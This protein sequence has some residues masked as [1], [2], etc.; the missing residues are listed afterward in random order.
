MDVSKPLDKTSVIPEFLAGGG[1]ISARGKKGEGA[2][3]R[4]RL[5]LKGG[6][7]HKI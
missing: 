2:V 1:E 3:F 5:P 4:I 7:G 6:R